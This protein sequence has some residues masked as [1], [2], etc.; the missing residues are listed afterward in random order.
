MGG[1]GDGSVTSDRRPKGK[2]KKKGNKE[3]E[4]DRNL[5]TLP[6]S[7]HFWSRS[8]SPG[9]ERRPRGPEPGKRGVRWSGFRRCSLEGSS[10]G[11]ERVFQ[12]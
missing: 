10:A 7:D 1:G 6:R 9:G 8:L 3:E 5:A 4:N 11:R 2:Q 12:V